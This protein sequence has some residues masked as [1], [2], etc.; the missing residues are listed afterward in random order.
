MSDI[1]LVEK[2]R[3]AG[4]TIPL[5]IADLMDA[6]DE[7]A[8]LRAQLQELRVSTGRTGNQWFTIPEPPKAAC[9]AS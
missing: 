1:D 6:A 5:S 9:Q 2:L 4:E 3:D 7:I 8:R